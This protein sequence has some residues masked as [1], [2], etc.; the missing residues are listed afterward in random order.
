MTRVDLRV[1]SAGEAF[2]LH[3]KCIEWR[4]THHD[5]DR[6]LHHGYYMGM[7]SSEAK[8]IGSTVSLGSQ[9]KDMAIS[10]TYHNVSRVHDDVMI[11]RSDTVYLSDDLRELVKTA[12]ATMPDEILFDT[13]IYTPCGL[14]I[15]ETP[16]EMDIKA[17]A[18]ANDY[19]A[20][21]DLA[22]RKGKGHVTGTR[23]YETPNEFGDII[24]TEHWQVQAFAWANVT[25]IAE[26]SLF[27]IEREFGKKSKEYEFAKNVFIAKEEKDS[28]LFIRVFGTLTAVTIDGTRIEIPGM[29]NSPLRLMHQYVFFYGEDGFAEELQSKDAYMED[30]LNAWAWDRQRE[31]RRFMVALFRLMGEYVDKTDETLSRPFSRRATRAGRTG[32]VG[33]V[34]TLSLRR[35]IYGDSENGTGRKITLAHLVRGH[36]RRQWY[37]SQNMHRAKWINAHRRGGHIDDTPVERPRLITVTK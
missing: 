32:N 15:M 34:T 3:T 21:V 14:V 5:E 4:K 12:E 24:G 7:I 23:N 33:R 18:K 13:D 28:G 25:S 8:T 37:P 9:D 31:I 26:E 29:R 16:I 19:E 17:L 30:E 35:S 22:I 2:D 20:L 11:S 1:D 10:R 6:L 36:W 27:Q